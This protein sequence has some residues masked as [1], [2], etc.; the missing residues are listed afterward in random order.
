MAFWR[1][2]KLFLA[3]HIFGFIRHR[4]VLHKDFTKY[5]KRVKFGN[6]HTQWDVLLSME[7]AIL[8]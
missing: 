8:L 1:A 4:A 5:K 6:F 2:L 7:K 3:I